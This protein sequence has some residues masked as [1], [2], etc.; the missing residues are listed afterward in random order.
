MAAYNLAPILNGITIFGGNTAGS[1]PNLPLA[2]GQVWT[3]AAGTTTPLGAY[4]TN[5]GTIWTNPIVLDSAG[6]VPGSIYFPNGVAYKFVV[7]DS[8]GNTIPDATYDNLIG[9]GDTSGAVSAAE[10]IAS[11][12]VPTYAGVAQFTTPGNTTATFQVGRRVQA[13]VTAGTAYG[14]ITSS[15]FGVATTV[16][17]DMDVGQ[18][19]DSGLTA[20]NVGFLGTTGNHVSVPMAWVNDLS[21]RGLTAT[22]VTATNLA[23]A[24]TG[25]VTGN[26]TG[27][28][29]GGTVSGTTGTFSSTVSAANGTTGTNVVNWSQFAQSL[30]TTGY[31]TLPGGLI[32][33]WGSATSLN[34]GG[35]LVTTFVTQGGIAF[36]NNNYAVYVQPQGTTTPPLVTLT[37][38]NL[39]KTGFQNNG[40]SGQG[41]V[42]FSYLAI[43][44]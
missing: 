33:Q 42:A 40:P 17:L 23:G 27:N 44:N 1:T 3:Y 21:L 19:L 10:W 39:T 26:L 32:I 14:T 28:V 9:I 30:G 35:S 22:S 13:T 20:V 12:A 29:T 5:A 31:V 6:R 4:Q 18:A 25:N 16:N 15:S 38:G 2:S 34:G 24:L 43:G 11:G 7:K 37:I 8:L 41:T 36:P